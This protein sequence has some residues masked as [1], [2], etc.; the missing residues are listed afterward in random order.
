MASGIPTTVRTRKNMIIANIHVETVGNKQ[1]SKCDNYR[2]RKALLWKYNLDLKT[3]AL[4]HLLLTD[5]HTV[6]S[7][8]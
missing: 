3:Y 1:H 8:V 5:I 2:L 6:I 7:L 4:Q